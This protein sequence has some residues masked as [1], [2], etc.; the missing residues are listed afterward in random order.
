METSKQQWRDFI[1]SRIWIIFQQEIEDREAYLMELFKDNDLLWN[2]DTIRGKLTELAFIKQ[3]PNS[4]I[5][6]LIIEE[7]NQ[8]EKEN[9]DG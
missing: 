3:V 8:R 4:I 2:S 9:V 5:A 7:A 6:S 1:E